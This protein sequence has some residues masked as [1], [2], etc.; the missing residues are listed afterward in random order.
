MGGGG[1]Y[2]A[3]DPVI[4]PLPSRALDGNLWKFVEA[5]M[6]TPKTRLRLQEIVGRIARSEEVGLEDRIYLQKFADRDAT[7][8]GWLRQAQRI[9]QGEIPKDGAGRLLAELNLG[10]AG[11]DDGPFDP[12][13]DDL[14]DWFSGAPSWLR[15]S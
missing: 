10:G 3:G 8:W 15:R 5:A 13:K 11:P 12:K 1:G 4:M 14:G 6:L 2:C 7:V 9:S